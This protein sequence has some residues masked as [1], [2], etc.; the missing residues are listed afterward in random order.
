MNEA[1]II[2][3]LAIDLAQH[4]N[5]RPLVQWLHMS[6]AHVITYHLTSVSPISLTN[7]QDWIFKQLVLCFLQVL[8]QLVMAFRFVTLDFLTM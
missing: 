2:C 7:S 3:L 1:H 8:T 4:S 6:L 5:I